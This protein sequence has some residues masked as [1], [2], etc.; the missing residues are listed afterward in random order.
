MSPARRRDIRAAAQLKSAPRTHKHTATSKPVY[1]TGNLY[2]AVSDRVHICSAT[3]STMNRQIGKYTHNA[4]P[5]ERARG[6]LACLQ[7][8]CCRAPLRLCRTV[9][10]APDAVVWLGMQLADCFSKVVILF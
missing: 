3:P 5:P 10:G 4:G 6:H 1:P 2:P 8:A 9:T 7:F